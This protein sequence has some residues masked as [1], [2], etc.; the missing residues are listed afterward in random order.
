MESGKPGSQ[1][2]CP[3]DYGK[4][5]GKGKIKV[6]PR[7]EDAL[8]AH[9]YC[10]TDSKC[11]LGVESKDAAPQN[12]LDT[13][14]TGFFKA[15]SVM[16]YNKPFDMG[17]DV[18]ELKV[19]LDDAGND[20]VLPLR[21]TGIK[22]LF[23]GEYSRTELLVAEK[24][25]ESSLA[26]IGDSITINVPLNLGYRPQEIEESGSVRYTIDYTYIKKVQTGREQNGTVIYEQQ[27]VRE[28]FLAPSKQVFF[29]R[30]G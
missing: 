21:L 17:N 7:F 15:S 8:Y 16:K 14:N 10:S 28:K 2:T 6:G 29:V 24:D 1:C 26:G 4:C 19:T 9:Y 23:S 11:V 27:L 25:L 22:M 18:F 30:S 5:E 20:L 13:I 3:Q 12:F